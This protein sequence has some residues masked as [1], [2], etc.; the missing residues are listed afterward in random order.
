[1]TT[2]ARIR[3]GQGFDVHPSPKGDRWRLAC[4]SFIRGLAA[5]DADVVLCL[6][7]A[8]LGAAA[9]DIDALPPQ[10][11]RWH[12]QHGAIAGMG[13]WLQGQWQPGNMD[14]MIIASGA[15]LALVSRGNGS[16]IADV[17]VVDPE[18]VNLK[19]TTTD[20]LGAVGR[21]EGIA[22]MVVV[23]LESKE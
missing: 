18:T 3:I 17:L 10:A 13:L 22:A 8:L 16:Y 9:G 4:A 20:G 14:A 21:G 7:D 1:V 6:I 5:S 2:N 11:L 19:A 15:R 23:L 12:S